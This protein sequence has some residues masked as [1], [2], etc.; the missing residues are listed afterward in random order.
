MTIIS[1]NIP[2]N[3]LTVTWSYD[4]LQNHA[5]G[6]VFHSKPC[7]GESPLG[8]MWLWTCKGWS[9]P[10]SLHASAPNLSLINSKTSL[11]G[12]YYPSRSIGFKHRKYEPTAVLSIM[13]SFSR[14]KISKKSKSL[15]IK[16]CLGGGWFSRFLTGREGKRLLSINKSRFALMDNISYG[17]IKLKLGGFSIIPGIHLLLS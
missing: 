13:G 9:C 16:V 4:F 11:E 12:K 7:P 10:E 6:N 15:C 17:P 5:G 3:P 8:V 1:S 14:G 2:Q